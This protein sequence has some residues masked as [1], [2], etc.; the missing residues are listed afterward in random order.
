MA[1]RSASQRAN[2]VRKQHS[3]EI[4]RRSLFESLEYRVLLAADLT[5]PVF[6]PTDL[7]LTVS[8]GGSAPVVQIRDATT[9]AT[10]ASVVLDEPTDTTIKIS[11]DGFN[12][13]FG[14]KVHIDLN[15]LS[16]LDTY[17]AAS[18]GV[19]KLEFNGGRDTPVAEDQLWVEGTGSYTLN[20]GLTIQS[21]SGIE[22]AVA[23][24]T[25]SGN[26]LVESASE[27]RMASSIINASNIILRAKPPTDIRRPD[28][29]D[30]L[31]TL[32]EPTAKIQLTGG[33]L[34]AN[35]ITLDADS[36]VNAIF[37]FGQTINN[38]ISLG[39]TKTDSNAIID[40]LGTTSIQASGSLTVSAHA[41]ITTNV[42]RQPDPNQPT[43]Q[44]QDAT[45][46]LSWIDSQSNIHIGGAASLQG[47][48][49][50][51]QSLNNVDTTTI[52]DGT[53][54]GTGSGATLAE[55]TIMGPTSLLVDGSA[56]ILGT[57]TVTLSA[58]S[59]R[60]A[61][62]TAKATPAGAAKNST[63]PPRSQ[64]SLAQNGAAT[65]D[66]N[67]DVAASVAL[68]TV[69]D[70]T[71]ATIDGAT[72]RSTAGA[73]KLLADASHSLTTTADGT[74]ASGASDSGVGIAVAIGKVAYD[75]SATVRGN[76][77]LAGT[78]ITVEGNFSNAAES[79]TATSGKSGSAA[80]ADLRFA[81]SLAINT[82]KL[83][84]SGLIDAGAVINASGNLTLSSFNQTNHQ[85]NATPLVDAAGTSL[86]AGISFALNIV[87]VSARAN[88]GSAATLSNVNHLNVQASSNNQSLTKAKNG[89]QGQIAISPFVATGL[90]NV[91][92]TATIEAGAA[93]VA[94]G[95]VTI[96]ATHAGSID[97]QSDGVT[98][99]ST[100][101]IGTAWAM[102]ILN[103]QTLANTARSLTAQNA[104]IRTNSKNK[105]TSNASASA[106][107]MPKNSGP[108]T[109]ADSQSAAQRNTLNARASRDG[110]RNSGT[111]S[112]P[113]AK[114]A[115]G[116]VSLAAAFGINLVTTLSQAAIKPGVTLNISN[117]TIVQSLANQDSDAKA[118]G[119]GTNGSTLGAGIGVAINKANV[120]NE[121]VIAGGA[122]V[123]TAGL[124]V[125]AD[126]LS[127]DDSTHVMNAT[128][129]SGAGQSD[130]GL[131]GSFAF[132]VNK[133][134][135]Y[136]RVDPGSTLNLG[137]SD[138]TLRA[139]SNTKTTVSA[140]PLQAATGQS[141][142]IGG[143]YA[144][145]IVDGT[146]QA[147]LG[148]QV[149][150]LSNVTISNLRNLTIDAQSTSDNSAISK[151]GA[152]SSGTLAL[153]AAVA[154]SIINEDTRAVAGYGN[155]LLGSG[156]VAISAS[157]AGV[158]ATNAAGDAQGG[159]AAAIG[160]AIALDFVTEET[161]ATTLRS[162]NTTGNIA[163]TSSAASSSTALATASA[164]GDKS[165]QPKN[166]NQK[167]GEQRTTA[168]SQATSNGA[169]PSDSTQA[170]PKATTGDGDVGVAAA[171]SF[172]VIKSTSQAKLPSG[173]RLKSAGTVTLQSDANVDP[174]ATADAK[175]VSSDSVNV[176]AAVAVNRAVIRNEAIVDATGI[177]D[178]AGAS[179]IAGMRNVSGDQQHISSANAISGAAQGNYSVA[180]AVAFNLVTSSSLAEVRADGS[181]A[182][183]L[184]GLNNQSLN[185]TAASTTNAA[186]RARPHDGGG[187]AEKVGVGASLAV[188]N[189]NNDTIAKVYDAVAITGTPSTI[190]DTCQCQSHHA[191]C[192]R[193]RCE[194]C[195]HC[196]QRGGSLCRSR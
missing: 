189:S 160:V 191:D 13:V 89:A 76:T 65:G 138:L 159:A 177:I 7:R 61:V 3:H 112:T 9:S 81:G 172:N 35:N 48:T 41:A 107:G 37:D 161:L 146:T 121:A 144:Q 110:A 31:Y 95:N 119:S 19:F 28:T 70:S 139:K 5:Y 30:P 111:A 78:T 86:G 184:V 133:L 91:D 33:S 55:T 106:K 17:V 88:I 132:N 102:A 187:N 123:N 141:L 157:R 58:T 158:H 47:N 178:A 69:M 147:V 90:V 151:A 104:T 24:P 52:A 96:D 193:E 196:D 183:S 99:G 79:M 21:Q 38:S 186:S 63:N 4:F 114:T 80:S 171:V 14:D 127:A 173:R 126:M 169:R 185:I 53:I 164:A 176:A 68:L 75:S 16:L 84:A 100:A 34:T 180:G 85:I 181:G 168:D 56:N 26:L 170:T 103:E 77:T 97:A 71:T 36:T 149:N 11:R 136:A 134:Q 128:A 1:K 135:T 12:D 39:G 129:K 150:T 54:G 66:G 148:D 131:A 188:N 20:F 120:T 87:D 49:V 122:S 174:S 93:I 175:A 18:G 101:A 25:I 62:T 140:L 154:W 50:T 163:I 98:A 152:A 32:Y 57:G 137:N 109:T 40:I 162:L 167:T 74:S 23:S 142:G 108:N 179:I 59:N 82:S 153:P 155:E 60:T 2:R 194:E 165:N 113:S 8:S 51:V 130:I 190:I 73:L 43:A 6:A 94:G 192:R 15:S 29:L 10:L 72:V 44:N 125:T 195:E 42:R 166:V 46:A 182:A 27:V 83:N 64:S 145:N 115:D 118:D 117:S 22:L 92:T 105:S 67:V 156:T 116:D 143:S 124:T 45:I